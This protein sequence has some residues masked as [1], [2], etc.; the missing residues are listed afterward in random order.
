[1]QLDDR[2]EKLGKKIR[3]AQLQKIP[4]IVVI[5]DREVASQTVA[6]RRHGQQ[7]SID[8]SLQQLIEEVT[9]AIQQKSLT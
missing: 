3:E 9:A 7:N 1:M 2:E 5:G 6:V 8:K 4:Y